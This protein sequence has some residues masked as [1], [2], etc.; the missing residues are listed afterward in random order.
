MSDSVYPRLVGFLGN[1]FIS[2][3]IQDL[4]VSLRKT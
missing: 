2:N 1:Y 4:R 3:L